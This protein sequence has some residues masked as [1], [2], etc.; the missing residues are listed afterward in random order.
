VAFTLRITS[1]GNSDPN[2]QLVYYTPDD[3][4]KELPDFVDKLG[5]LNKPF[6]FSRHQLSLFLRT[7]NENLKEALADEDEEEDEVQIIE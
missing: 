5:F 4:D 6:S 7:L 3:L 1:A 2:E